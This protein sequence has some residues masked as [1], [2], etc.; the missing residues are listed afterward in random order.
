MK[1]RTLDALAAIG[2]VCVVLAAIGSV[3]LTAW[4]EKAEPPAV[5]MLVGHEEARSG[6]WP[7]VQKAHLEKE[8][9]C[10]FCGHT[11]NLQVHHVEDFHEHPELELDPNNLITLCGP[12]PDS[13]N[14]HLLFGHLG[15]YKRINPNV[16][17]DALRYRAEVE[18]SKK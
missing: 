15:D 12:A 14:C 7:A 4:L 5:P 8:P 16:R 1:Q 17:K 13:H 6:K 11:H 2:I 10:A 9:A 3:A 18:A